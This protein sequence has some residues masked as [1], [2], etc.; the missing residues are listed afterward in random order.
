METGRTKPVK[1]Y[2]DPHTDLIDGCRKGD[3]SSQFMIY[4]LYYKAM[5]NTALR[6]VKDNM[7]AEDIMQESFL[8]AFEKIDSYSGTVGFGAW[9]KK[10]VQ[11]RALD[12]IKKSNKMVCSDIDTL[13]E[14]EEPACEHNSTDDS[15]NQ[16]YA[17]IKDVISRLPEK[18]RNIITLHFLDGYDY[19]EISQIMTTTPAT[20]RSQ[21]CRARRLIRSEML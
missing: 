13:S 20:V 3:H 6:I 5:Y 4:K 21:I 15:V 2:V 1:T 14:Y 12:S 10:I 16:R 19:S 7:E 17:S 11:N 8:T 9:L 18:Y